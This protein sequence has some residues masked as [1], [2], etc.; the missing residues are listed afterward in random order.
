MTTVLDPNLDHGGR[1]HGYSNFNAHY[2]RRRP[3]SV[4]NVPI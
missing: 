3:I 4:D 1:G 2:A